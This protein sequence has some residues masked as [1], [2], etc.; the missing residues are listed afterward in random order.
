MVV[1]L[2]L[3]QLDYCLVLDGG[4]ISDHE[5]CSPISGCVGEGVSTAAGFLSPSGVVSTPCLGGTRL[6]GIF[7]GGCSRIVFS[8]LSGVEL[9]CWGLGGP[10]GGVRLRVITTVA[11]SGV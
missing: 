6:A 10:G 7:F 9:W 2:V 5:I 4:A 11:A 1:D 3:L 8:S